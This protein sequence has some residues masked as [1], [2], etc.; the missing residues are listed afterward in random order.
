MIM[1]TFFDVSD[2]FFITCHVDIIVALSR[3]AEDL[4]WFWTYGGASDPGCF[5]V[6]E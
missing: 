1:K 4:V 6:A 5:A 2:N 3:Y